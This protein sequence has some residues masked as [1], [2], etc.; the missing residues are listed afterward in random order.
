MAHV[1]ISTSLLALTEA[2]Q[3]PQSIDIHLRGNLVSTPEGIGI[4]IEAVG[5][6]FP[7]LEVFGRQ[8]W[9]GWAG[10]G[11]M[12]ALRPLGQAIEYVFTP[13]GIRDMAM[14]AEAGEQPNLGPRPDLEEW[15]ATRGVQPFGHTQLDPEATELV[16]H[17]IEFALGTNVFAGSLIAGAGQASRA[18][19]LGAR[20]RVP[21][22]IR[23]HN[24]KGKLVGGAARMAKFGAN[25]RP[26]SLSKAIQRHAGPNATSWVSKSG[27]TIYEN[28]LTGRQI[29]VD[30]AGYFRIFQPKSFGSTK[31]AY[32]D[33]LGK[34]PS[35]ARVV[36]G[37]VVKNIPLTGKELQKATHFII[38]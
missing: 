37:G 21:A 3:V 9:L 11:V 13:P 1:S 17:Y 32:L 29:V 19:R 4:E 7:S 12:T 22:Q 6:G 34:V 36:K 38:E 8:S 24:Q 27:K 5:D 30:P 23:A 16:G 31:G 10:S 26:A 18:T 2:Y 14:R 35:P 15:N 33:M 25:W 28:P 20:T